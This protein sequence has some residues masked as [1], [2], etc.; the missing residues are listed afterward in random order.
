VS[1]TINPEEEVDFKNVPLVNRFLRSTPKAK[2]AIIGKWY[3]IQDVV[4]DHKAK[5][6]DMKKNVEES[7]GLERVI[8][9]ELNPYYVDYVNIFESAKKEIES[10]NK[11]EEAQGIIEGSEEI[12]NK[13]SD[14]MKGAIQQ[15]DELN[16][17][18]NKD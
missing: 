10:I 2:W 1:Q 12:D 9:H 5:V 14:I 4:M 17:K 15:I 11:L 13:I 18:Y 16:K 7:G 3:D 8:K 6:S